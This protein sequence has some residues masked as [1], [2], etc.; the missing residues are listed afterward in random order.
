MQTSDVADDIRKAVQ[1]RTP[2]DSLDEDFRILR[3]EARGMLIRVHRELTNGGPW[4]V[5][6]DRI[7]DI[8]TVWMDQLRG[9]K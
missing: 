7:L 8:V 2:Q 1:A 5:N 4:R 9:L 6:E 3:A